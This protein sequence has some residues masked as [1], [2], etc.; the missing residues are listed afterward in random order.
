MS[1]WTAVICLRRVSC[2]RKV[3]LQPSYPRHLYFSC[4]SCAWICLRSRVPVAKPFS[5]PCHV[6]LNLRTSECALVKWCLRCVSR[7]KSFG[8]NACGHLKGRSPVCDL[9]CSCNLAFRLKVFEQPCHGQ[10]MVLRSDGRGV[11]VLGVVE[12][13][14]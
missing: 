3:S 12:G 5:H 7:R 14:C 4:P 13:V 2:L 11:R 10:G 6:H 8:Q 1:S 9:M